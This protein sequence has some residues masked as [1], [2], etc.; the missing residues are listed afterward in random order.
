VITY[1]VT[2][3]AGNPAV[4]VTRTVIVNESQIQFFSVPDSMG[5]H[6]IL[7]LKREGDTYWPQEPGISLGPSLPSSTVYYFDTTDPLVA[8][9]LPYLAWDVLVAFGEGTVTLTVVTENLQHSDTLELTVAA[10][11]TAP[12]LGHGVDSR[13]V[14]FL[15]VE[16]LFG[17]D[18]TIYLQF[19]E[20]VDYTTAEDTDNYTVS[21][22]GGVGA[23]PNEAFIVDG[24][25]RF[26]GLI[27]G[28]ALSEGQEVTVD[29]QNVEDTSGNVISTQSASMTYAFPR[30]W[31]NT[32]NI[33]I[34]S[35]YI[36]FLSGVVESGLS[37]Q[38]VKVGAV[39]HGNGLSLPNVLA[40][41]SVSGDGSTTSAL[42]AREDPYEFEAGSY[43]LYIIDFENGTISDPHT[44]VVP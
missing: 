37:P 5:A 44:V 14:D 26:V 8:E 6:E 7:L 22:N 24:D 33:Y 31:S 19:T 9:V 25:Q 30:E 39:A 34:Q 43:D 29:V 35:N 3:A 28:S 11:T 23:N 12:A 16:L 4:Q 1:D 36:I 18:T 17:D 2:D 13:F 10:D 42:M 38:Y 32:G 21:I 41:A 40:I 15:D 20:F 27:L